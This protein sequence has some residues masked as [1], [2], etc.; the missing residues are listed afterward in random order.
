MKIRRPHPYQNWLPPEDIENLLN[1]SGFD[2]IR[3]TSYLTMPKNIPVFAAFCNYFLSL[4]PGFR[5]FNLVDLVIAR[6]V[7]TARRDEDL[8]VSVIVPCRNERGNIEDAVRRIPQMGRET[9]IIFVDGN[10]TDGTVEEIECQIKRQ[11]ERRI[12]LIRQAR[13]IF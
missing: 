10:S 4:L 11:P 9:E 6:P 5:L 3:S 12:C 7:P 13:D 8:S 1:L 2:V